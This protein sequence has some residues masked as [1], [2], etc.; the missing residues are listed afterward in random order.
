MIARRAGALVAAFVLPFVLV[1]CTS[2]DQ[3]GRGSPEN[4]ATGPAAP[5][6]PQVAKPWQEG[7]VQLGVNIFWEDS[8][9]DDA[10]VTRAKARRLLDHLVSLNV[11]SVALNFPFVMANAKSNSVGPDDE[12]TPGPERMEIFLEEAAASRMRV[13]VR[14]LLD[15]RSLHPAWRGRIEPA[16]RDRWFASYGKFLRSYAEVA[17]RHD[18]AELFVGVELNSLQTDRRWDSLIKSVRKT[19]D[20]QL[21]YSVNFDEFER[22]SKTPDVDHVGVDAYFK[23]LKPDNASVKS[24]TAS[25]LEW[26]DEYAGRQKAKKL[27]LH[28]VGIAAQDG[29][30]HHP[31][32]WG[33]TEVPLN[34][35]VQKKWY[36]AVCAAAEQRQLAGLYFWNIRMHAN[37]GTEDPE[38]PDRLTFVDRP[39]EAVLQECYAKLGSINP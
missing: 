23:V 9:K 26:L 14:P 3:P 17:Q 31:A 1:A 28:E 13:A 25:W 12:L 8:K 29:A 30:Y 6:V 34:L 39:A 38:Q 7:A 24:L 4:T 11:N 35:T 22:G 21:A 5:A 33:S 16:S 32:Q 10:E 37:P 36:Q 2:S 15:E 19:F 20:G 27:V 18:V